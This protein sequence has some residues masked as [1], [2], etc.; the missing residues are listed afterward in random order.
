MT[1][2]EHIASDSNIM[3]NNKMTLELSNHIKK[4]TINYIS[5]KVCQCVDSNKMN[6]LVLN[7]S[8]ILELEAA[9]ILSYLLKK[10]K[11]LEYLSI[12]G[13]KI[14]ND[15]LKL[16]LSAVE[17]RDGYFSLNVEGVA[18]SLQ[19]LKWIRKIVN[20]DYRKMILLDEVA[21]NLRGISKASGKQIKRKFKY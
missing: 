9:Q 12:G 6:E 20:E 16:I 21:E 3:G 5:R 13:N 8:N 10:S 17:N 1:I 7:K 4:I 14:E 15:S 18:M 2:E 11:S 19:T